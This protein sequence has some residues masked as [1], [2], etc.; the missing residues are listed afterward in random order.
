MIRF[1][2]CKEVTAK[3]SNEAAPQT[4][5]VYVVGSTGAA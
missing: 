2:R 4:D 1:V 3:D 5:E